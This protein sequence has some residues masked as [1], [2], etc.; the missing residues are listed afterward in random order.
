[1][2]LISLYCC[3]PNQP[4]IA[5]F[6]QKQPQHT[7]RPVSADQTYN[8]PNRN[9]WQQPETILKV[10]GPLNNKVVADVGA[11]FGFFTLKLLKSASKVIAIDIDPVSIS[12]LDSLKVSLPQPYGNKLETRLASA[13]NPFLRP[14]EVDALLL[15]NTYMYLENRPAYLL[16]LKQ[17]LKPNGQILIVDF[18]DKHTSIGPPQQTRVAQGVAEQELI[19]AGFKIVQS[20]DTALDFQYFILATHDLGGPAPQK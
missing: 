15:V 19:Q 2:V 5:E 9:I 18:K 13:N 11:G 16:K 1:M 14:Q 6:G 20:D 12:F 3:Q 8:E 4:T 7:P 17:G 10:I